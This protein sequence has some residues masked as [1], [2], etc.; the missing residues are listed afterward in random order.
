MFGNN[1]FSRLRL[2]FFKRDACTPVVMFYFL[3]DAA[4]PIQ[5]FQQCLTVAG[6]HEKGQIITGKTEI[7]RPVT[8][9]PALYQRTLRQLHQIKHRGPAR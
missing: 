6:K 8:I 4:V 9:D 1:S 5:S 7:L 2:A 3:L